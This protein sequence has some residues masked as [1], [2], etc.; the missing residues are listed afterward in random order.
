MIGF[1]DAGCA[2]AGGGRVLPGGVGVSSLFNLLTDPVLRVDAP[3]L[4]QATVSLPELYAALASDA[5]TGFPALRPHQRHAW[6]AFLVQLG[7]IAMHRSAVSD[8]PAEASSWADLLRALTR[9]YPDDEPWELA[10]ADITRPAFLQPPA[11]ARERE[12]DYVHAIGTPDEL[13]ML[14]TSKN[15]DLKASVAR[16]AAPDDWVFAIVTL[17]TM[18]GFGGAGNYGISRMNGGMGNRPAFSLAPAGGPGAHVMRDIASL[19]QHRQD[20]SDRYPMSDCGAALLWTVPWDGSR[21][22]MLILSDLDPFYLDVCR[23]VRLLAGRDGRLRGVRAVSKAARIDGSGLNGRTADPWT[24]VNRKLGKSLT[25]AAG[26]FTYKRVAEY[27]TSPDWE[28]PVL[29][30]PT[31]EEQRTA[32]EMR[33][34]ARAMVRG[35]GKTE[36]YHERIVPLRSRAVRAIGTDVLASDVGA[37]AEERIGQVATVQ[38]ILSH[39]IQVFVAGGD[40]GGTSPEGRA[41]ARPWLNR[42]DTFVD[43]R[44]FEDL[45]TELESAPDDR[46]AVRRSWLRR[47]VDG[48]RD[49]LVDAT[50]SLPCP[51]IHRYRARANAESLFEGRI[52]GPKGLPFLFEEGIRDS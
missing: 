38:R 2:R 34:V 7:A 48:A 20:I 43:A 9:E 13:D 11:G 33:L 50:N 31:A 4:P 32:V 36:G 16:S 6:H 44:F 5:V 51:V 18:E 26:G 46:P 47:I 10:V 29:L 28:T 8:P 3:H 30:R 12:D 15:H 41:R 22:E 14:V 27:L 1:G 24:P 19:R 37:I 17:Q 39:A 52:R 49:A 35:Q 23:R 21:D 45:Q 40:A 42:L 25:L